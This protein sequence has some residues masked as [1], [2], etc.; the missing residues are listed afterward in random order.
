M[1][2]FYSFSIHVE[3]VFKNLSDAIVVELGVYYKR[4]ICTLQLIIIEH[5]VCP[6]LLPVLVTC[7]SGL[8]RLLAPLLIQ[9]FEGL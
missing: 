9:Y 4:V 7:S 1:Q 5:N 2:A 8:G 3:N 6:L